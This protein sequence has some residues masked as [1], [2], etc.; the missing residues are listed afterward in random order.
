MCLQK[1][2]EELS[3]GSENF[4]LSV[5][6]FASALQPAG[7]GFLREFTVGQDSVSLNY[8]VGGVEVEKTI[9]VARGFN[10][11]IVSYS[12][13]NNSGAPA[14][15]KVKVIANSRSIHELMSENNNLSSKIVEGRAFAINSP[16][17]FTTVYSDSMNAAESPVWYKNFRYRVEEERGEACVEDSY[18]PGFFTLNV[19]AKSKIDSKIIA[20]AGE[21][22][23]E[24]SAAFKKILSL[25]PSVSKH[26]VQ[27]SGLFTILSN[28]DSFLFDIDS[29]K[30]VIAGYPWFGEWGR[31]AMISLLG[32]TLA[33]GKFAESEKIL[34]RFLNK[35]YAG[36]IPTNFDA[37]KPQYYDF[38]GT[39]WMI[40]R[41][42]D[43]V[44]YVGADKGKAFLHTYWWSL[45]D[46]VKSYSEGVKD[47]IL[48]HES[49]T[50]M[51]TLKRNDAVEVQG[52][53]YN[54]LKTMEELGKVMNDKV[55]YHE[56]INDFEG[57]F[58]AKYWNGSYLNDTLTDNS[59][60]PNQVLLLSMDYCPVLAA[61]ALKILDVVEKELLT[62]F[63]LRTLSRAHKDYRGKYVGNPGER[64]KAY[65][66]GTVWPWLL[67]PYVKACVKFRKNKFDCIKVLAPLLNEHLTQA[68]VG[69]ISEIFDGDEPHTPR[70]CISQAWSAAEII[71]AMIEDVQQTRA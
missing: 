12:I 34:E 51:D 28:A 7:I 63:G 11:V 38:D 27:D 10:A 26:V 56:L 44:D 65:H 29:K 55:D 23:S 15:L 6:E 16:Q 47:G 58:M 41:V 17:A 49:G 4:E 54:A 71:R 67:G 57:N 50:W 31:D 21:T 1:L 8:L 46:V 25:R 52:L 24:A 45:K 32:L 70:G 68:G 22:E 69:T 36:R 53:W 18:S 35:I 20:V 13:S 3:V 9:R 62:P 2:D 19:P 37:G 61:D 43:Y 60:R 48:R 40:D 64:E 39:L 59:L 30:S 5:N 33:R 14:S 66:N 42:K